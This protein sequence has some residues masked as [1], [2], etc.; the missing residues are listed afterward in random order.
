VRKKKLEPQPSFHVPFEEF[1]VPELD[2]LM[3]HL[4]K[5]KPDGWTIEVSTIEDAQHMDCMQ[6]LVHILIHSTDEDPAPRT[7]GIMYQ[8]CANCKTA[9]RVL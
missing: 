3:L 8:Y 1:S 2:D 7:M 9:V 6:P 4:A 5:V